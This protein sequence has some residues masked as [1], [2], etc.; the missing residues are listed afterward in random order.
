[1]ILLFQN[2]TSVT[3]HSDLPQVYTQTL[4]DVL[5]QDAYLVPKGVSGLWSQCPAIYFKRE[6]PCLWREFQKF[7]Y[8]N[9][10]LTATCMTG[11]IVPPLIGHNRRIIMDGL[12]ENVGMMSTGRNLA[13][14]YLNDIKAKLADKIGRGSGSVAPKILDPSSLSP[15][16]T[17]NIFHSSMY[18]FITSHTVYLTLIMQTPTQANVR[19]FEQN[20]CPGIL[21]GVWPSPIRSDNAASLALLESM[22]DPFLTVMREA[23]GM[24][25]ERHSEDFLKSKAAAFVKGFLEGPAE[26]D[27]VIKAFADK[28]CRHG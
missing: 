1:M 19:Y 11:P 18:V 21:T 15:Q 24:S 8:S 4:E 13:I 25:S 3:F 17:N 22:T 12:Q 14:D 9:Q 7:P 16:V 28:V 2:S 26:T 20:I 6:Q 10:A 27:A 5:T 23:K